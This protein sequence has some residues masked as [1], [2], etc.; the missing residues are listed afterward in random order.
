MKITL[1]C[2]GKTD[3][4][5]LIEGI[6]KYTKRLKFYVNFNIVVLPDIKNV[7]SFSAEQQ[8]DKEALLILKQLQPQDFVVLL[9]EHGKEFRSLEFSVYLEKMMIQSVQHLVFVIG[10]PYGFDQKIYDR[11]KSKISLSK[12]TFSHQMIR[13]FFTEQLYRAFSIMKGEPYHHE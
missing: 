7:K 3:E 9:D 8:K 10:G 13:L 11:A 4:K 12:M 5:Y 6:E 1:L 2:I